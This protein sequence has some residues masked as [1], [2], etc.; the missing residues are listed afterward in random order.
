MK[1]FSYLLPKWHTDTV[2]ASTSNDISHERMGLN[3]R[4]CIEQNDGVGGGGIV[5]SDQD[6]FAKVECSSSSIS[7]F[8]GFL[9]I[10]DTNFLTGCLVQKSLRQSAWA[11]YVGK[12]KAW[13]SCMSLSL[14]DSLGK[15]C[16][17]CLSRGILQL[18]FPA[19]VCLAGLYTEL[20]M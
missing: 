12:W 18:T 1:Y 15:P 3:G 7:M 4:W 14:S 5:L 11:G 17:V 10:S 13:N 6:T 19:H 8:P 2:M 20:K 16:S 9:S